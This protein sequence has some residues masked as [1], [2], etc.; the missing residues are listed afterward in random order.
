MR[1]VL[2]LCTTDH[3]SNL[4]WF[5]FQAESF[6]NS[7]VMENYLS[8]E[9]KEEITQMVCITTSI[10]FHPTP[11]SLISIVLKGTSL[12]RYEN[13]FNEFLF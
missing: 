9:V 13:K 6:G 4:F 11:I 8:D 10:L 12:N 2:L 3:L 1:G 5:Y 7:F